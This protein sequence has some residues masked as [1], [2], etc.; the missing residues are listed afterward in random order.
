MFKTQISRNEV[1]PIWKEEFRLKE[2]LPTNGALEFAIWHGIYSVDP[3][4]TLPE[5]TE[6]RLVGKVRLVTSRFSLAGFNGELELEHC[7]KDIKEATVHV[8]IGF[9]GQ[10]YPLPPPPEFHITIENPTSKPLGMDLDT[11]DEHTVYVENV[12]PLGLVDLYNSNS[13]P[14]ERLLAGHFITQV[15]GVQGRASELMEEINK[16]SVLRLVVRRPFVF[17]VAVDKKDKKRETGMNF[18]RRS[19][20]GSLIINQM[21]QGPVMEWNRRHPEKEVHLGDRIVA[22]NG[23]KGRASDMAKAMKSLDRFIMTIVRKH[24]DLEE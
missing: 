21:W 5:G 13:K 7:G 24:D 4:V 2:T 15:N 10:A 23:V 14:T 6:D 11:Q 22:V 19:Y 8:K 18:N 16:R 1:E 3:E 9:V 17:C 12:R 20:A